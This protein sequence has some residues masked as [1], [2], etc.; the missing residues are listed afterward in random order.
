M[1][2]NDAQNEMTDLIVDETEPITLVGGA[3]VSQTVLNICLSHAPISVA[4]DS[5]ADTLAQKGHS[6]LAVIGDLDSLSG[7]GRACFAD[8]LHLIPD[9]HNTDFE[10]ALMRIAAPLILAAGFLGGRLDHT[11]ATLN[12]LVRHAGRPV[13]LVGAEDVAF[14]VRGDIRLDLPEDTPLALLPLRGATVTTT[15]LRWNL[16]KQRMHP[17]G[18]ISSSNKTESGPVRVRTDVPLILT[19][20]LASLPDAIAA[21]RAR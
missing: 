15:G 18:L 11:L 1:L 17:A 3:P 5:G 7:S 9:Q 4:A 19:L 14:V 16:S 21:V 2:A 6:P 20:P 13:V 10:K 8:R 12:V